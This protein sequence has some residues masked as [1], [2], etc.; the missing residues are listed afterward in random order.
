MQLIRDI[1][2]SPPRHQQMVA[3]L[4][5]MVRE[6]G[7]FSLA[8]GV[9]S[10]AEHRCCCEMGFELGQGYYY[11]KPMPAPDLPTPTIGRLRPLF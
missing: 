5:Q 7:S 10:E 9:E 11:G 3:K 6:L 1:H 2:L 4:V 8:E